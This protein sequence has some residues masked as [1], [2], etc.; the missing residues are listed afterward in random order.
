MTIKAIISD[1]GGVLT[2]KD[3]FSFD[4]IW[5]ERLG[6]EKNGGFSDM[7][8]WSDASNK[9]TRGEISEDEVWEAVLAPYG[10]SNEEIMEV[11]ES[12]WKPYYLNTE[13]ADFI[14]GFKPTYKTGLLS[15]AW[16]GTREVFVDKYHFDT[17]FDDM[18]ISGEVKLMKPEAKIY[19]LAATRLGI[20]PHEAIFIDDQLRN[21]Q[22][23]KKAGLNTV[24]FQS[25]AQTIEDITTLLASL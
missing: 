13:L 5:E 15:N 3:D 2:H 24:H 6:L 1:V 8:F 11:K 19:Q 7:V 4:N 12:F 14:T 20:E 10:L 22:G 16:P 17:M 18:I 25:N 9:S 23:A 21:I